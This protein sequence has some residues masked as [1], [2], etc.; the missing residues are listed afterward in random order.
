MTA[1]DN[2]RNR[3][4]SVTSAS[5]LGTIFGIN[6]SQAFVEFGWRSGR[7]PSVIVSVASEGVRRVATLIHNR[8][9]SQVGNGP[10][11]HRRSPGLWHGGVEKSSDHRKQPLSAFYKRVVLGAGEH[12]LLWM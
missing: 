2:F 5:P 9:A 11:S 4:I 10:L 12:G 7:N 6:D 3:L 8:A 1:R